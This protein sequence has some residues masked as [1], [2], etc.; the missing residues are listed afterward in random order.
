VNLSTIPEA[1]TPDRFALGSNPLMFRRVTVLIVALA[2]G[3]C[4]Q[5]E[6]P[7]PG[8]AMHAAATCEGNPKE[9]YFVEGSFESTR[10]AEQAR[11]FRRFA[12]EALDEMGEPSLACGPIGESYRLL[13]ISPFNS[14]P[15]FGP[16]MV[17]LTKT[18]TSWTINGMR[19]HTFADG[20]AEDRRVSVLSPEMAGQAISAVMTYG[21]WR[22]RGLLWADLDHRTIW[23]GG[24]W[25]VEG[26][27]GSGYNAVA[28]VN[29]NANSE[30]IT[31]QTLALVF[32]SSAQ[33]PLGHIVSPKPFC[34]DDDQHLL[35]PMSD[36]PLSVSCP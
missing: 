7:E 20:L 33:M 32:L 9:A 17:R 12:A 25:I 18:G 26:R 19:L 34:D 5:T 35:V 13:W 11:G 16:V 15:G 21:L 29:A 31:L 24:I 28:R 27:R 1:W 36:G 6:L 22:K 30:E 4:A 23:E 10:T 14:T 3:A 2:S 8:F